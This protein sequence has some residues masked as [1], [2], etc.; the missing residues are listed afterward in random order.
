M[1]RDKGKQEALLDSHTKNRTTKEKI[2][3]NYFF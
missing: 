1:F 3:K 2:Q